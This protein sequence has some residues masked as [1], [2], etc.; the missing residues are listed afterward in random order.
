MTTLTQA[1]QEIARHRAESPGNPRPSHA[2]FELVDQ[3]IHKLGASGITGFVIDS[4]PADTPWTSIADVLGILIWNTPDN[5]AEIMHHA[6]QWLRDATDERHVFV[7]LHLEV[8]PFSDQT[9]MNTILTRVADIFPAQAELCR[10][11]IASRAKL[12]A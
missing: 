12:P 9:E 7:A 11:V 8:Y 3:L 10:S 6:E 1:Y 4:S 2:T 5:G